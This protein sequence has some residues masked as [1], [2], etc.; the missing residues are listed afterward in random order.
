MA[1]AICSSSGTFCF[2]GSSSIQDKIK[3]YNNTIFISQGAKYT[4]VYTGYYMKITRY[5]QGGP[6]SV[7]E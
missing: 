6:H 5:A 4:L 7:L 2:W 1:F 3:L